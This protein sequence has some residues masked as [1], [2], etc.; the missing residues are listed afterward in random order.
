MLIHMTIV[1]SCTT[2][3]LLDNEVYSEGAMPP[4]VRKN[5]R[6]WESRNG[7]LKSIDL[8]VLT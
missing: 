4:V 7:N 1:R 3:D 6:N 2:E 5:A 8:H